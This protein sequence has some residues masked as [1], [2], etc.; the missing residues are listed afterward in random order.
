MKRK[1]TKVLPVLLLVAAL[2]TVST[3]AADFQDVPADS[4]YAT[5]VTWALQNGVTTGTSSTTFSPSATCTRG[6]VVTFLWR[7]SGCP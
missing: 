5:A 3:G 4:Y 2:L 6:Q 7:A 1:L